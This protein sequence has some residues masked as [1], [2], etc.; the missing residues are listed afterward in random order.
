MKIVRHF[1]Y[2]IVIIGVAAAL[3]SCASEP[4]V[5]DLMARALPAVD[6]AARGETAPVGTGNADAADDP[7]IWHNA[8]DP[9]ASLIVGTDKKA[10]LYVY[11]L[12][13]KT[14]SFL[15]AGLVNNVDLISTVDDRVIVVASD[16]N[17]P[18]QSKLALFE[19]DT[20]KAQLRALGK[21]D[22]GAGEGYG[23]C[24]YPASNAPQGTLIDVIA[25][26]KQGAIH[27]IRIDD[28]LRGRV[29]K[30]F[31]VPT[32]PEGCVVN[33]D[34]LYVGEEDAGIWRFDLAGSDT[35]GTM[36][37]RADGRQLVA[38]VEG[39]AIARG[40][41]NYLIAS[42]QGD[43]AYSVYRLPDHVYLGRFRIRGGTVSSADETD[44]IEVMTGDFGPDYPSGLMIAQDGHN[45]PHAQNF[46]LVAW[47]DVV[48]ALGLE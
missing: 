38:D 4:R 40:R 29:I 10:G 42:S 14:R 13:G 28:Q 41:T 9:A 2:N 11:G 35:A 24:I 39:L 25:V 32:Q 6:V 20:A 33:G 7:A 8:G 48:K 16:R 36:I 37:A 30:S 3:A 15:D 22:S 27:H 5:S 45:Q 19:L 31:A 47:A 23:V 43:Y 18:L 44:G 46:K 34:T 17:D 21:V 26:L 12:D 1:C